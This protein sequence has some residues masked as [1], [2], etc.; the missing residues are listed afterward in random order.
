M[1]RED[2]MGEYK[3]TTDRNESTDL[4]T[5]YFVPSWHDDN[6]IGQSISIAPLENNEVSICMNKIY[7]KFPSSFVHFIFTEKETD[8]LISA[9]QECKERWKIDRVIKK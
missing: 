6:V 8:I 2:N 5:A 7:D 4:E 1:S 3:E 9:L